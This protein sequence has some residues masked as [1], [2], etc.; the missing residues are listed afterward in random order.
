MLRSGML[1]LCLFFAATAPAVAQRGSGMGY[2]M[3]PKPG[4]NGPKE[5]EGVKFNQNLGGMLPTTLEFYDH[6]EKPI[7]IGQAIGGKPTIFVLAYYRCPKLCNQVLTGVLDALKD[8]REKDA[9]FI[10]GSQFNVVVV[11]VDPRESAMTIARPK[12]ESYMREY[13]GHDRDVPGWLFLTANHG[14]GTNV[15]DAETKIHELASAAGYEYVLS[16]FNKPHRYD[17]NRGGWVNTQNETLLVDLPRNYDYQHA[18]G[19]MLVTPEGKISSYLLGINYGARDVRLGLVQASSN[20]IGTYF[21]RNVSQ[22]C[23]VYDDVKG[24]YKPT[25]RWTAIIAFPVMLGMF[26][27]AYRTIRRGLREKPLTL[28][29]TAKPEAPATSA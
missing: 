2:G 29:T 17:S 16:A 22:Y 24:H 25:L 7:T 9:N 11:S 26:Y 21:E 20:T 3:A 15:K 1:I 8:I 13:F 19:I 18:S 4:D 5:P 27:M 23:Y 14:Q 28:P 12:R 10:A 6:N